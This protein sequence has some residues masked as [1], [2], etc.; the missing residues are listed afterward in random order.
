M[1]GFE[2]LEHL[3]IEFK[4]GQQSTVQEEIRNIRKTQR[5]EYQ[6]RLMIKDQS[7][8]SQGL[9][10]AQVYRKNPIDD[11]DPDIHDE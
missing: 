7:N 9:N 8:F 6:G 2:G 5:E 10:K 4:D 1:Q 11:K 3:A